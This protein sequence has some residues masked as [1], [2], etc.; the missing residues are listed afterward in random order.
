MP[1]KNH[2]FSKHIEKFICR[3][4]I[5]TGF[6]GNFSGQVGARI[7]DIGSR[8]VKRYLFSTLHFFHFRVTWR[9][10]LQGNVPHVA[11]NVWLSEFS[12]CVLIP[13]W[14]KVGSINGIIGNKARTF[15]SPSFFMSKNL[16][17]QWKFNKNA[18][19]VHNLKSI[20]IVYEKNM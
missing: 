13:N 17:I 19:W 8:K 14:I 1:Q 15:P 5:S 16:C 4:E 12:V 6:C 20:L 11:R 9:S 7:D 10:S 18:P 2:C 3:R